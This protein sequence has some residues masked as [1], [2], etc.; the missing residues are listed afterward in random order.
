MTDN[1]KPPPLT[2]PETVDD[3]SSEDEWPPHLPSKVQPETP[4]TPV[5]EHD[6]RTPKDEKDNESRKRTSK[7]VDDRPTKHFTNGR[8]ET[9]FG[10]DNVK[11]SLHFQSSPELLKSYTQRETGHGLS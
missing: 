8:D 7:D 1:R 6:L 9:S 11:R 3:E 2:Q 10:I 4:E 5:P